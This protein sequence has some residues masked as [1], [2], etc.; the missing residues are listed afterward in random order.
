MSVDTDGPEVETVEAPP[1]A[2]H[3]GRSFSLWFLAIPIA[4]AVAAAALTFFLMAPRD[5]DLMTT[6]DSHA[7]AVAVA[8]ARPAPTAM[9]KTPATSQR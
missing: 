2:D 3:R 7:V 1:A 6:P 8:N 4:L 9:Q 5:Q